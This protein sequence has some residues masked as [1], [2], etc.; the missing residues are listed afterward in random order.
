MKRHERLNADLFAG[1]QRAVIDIGSNTVRLVVYGGSLRSPT[2]IWNEK[3]TARLGKDP[4]RSGS[5]SEEAM[6]L[7]LQGLGRYAVLLRDLGIADVQVVATAA[8]RDAANGAEFLDR[9]RACGLEPRLLSGQE[10]AITGTMGVLCACPRA[11]GAVADL[12]GGSLELTRIDGK[13]CTDGR[14]LPL[15][16]LRLAAMRQ[17][18]STGFKRAVRRELRKAAW[19]HA[20]DRTLYLVGGTF[21]AMASYAIGTSATPIDDQHG[22]GMNADAALRL[23]RSVARK[24]PGQL[25]KVPKIPSM[26][27]AMLPDTAALFGILLE[28]LRPARVIFSA[29][30]LREGLLFERLSPSARAQ[31]P[32]LAGIA[33]FAAPRGGR[34][35]LAARVAGW[36]V[37]A[38]PAAGSGTERLRLAV[39][40]LALASMQT[41]PNMRLPQ[42]LDWALHKRWIDLDAE[43]RAML[44]AAL[45]ANC[46]ANAVP[47]ELELIAD[48]ATLREAMCWGLAIRLCRRLG[49]NSLHS[50]EASALHVDDTKLILLLGESVAA[51]RHRGLE[52]DLARLGDAL[53]LEPSIEIV[54]DTALPNRRLAKDGLYTSAA[55]DR[56]SMTAP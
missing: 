48:A 52:K 12:G 51:L 40:M 8:V 45:I 15:G 5:L 44:A 47:P 53:G 4:G 54:R 41:D 7:A 32:L 33:A 27:A 9:V 19:D 25:A 18:G 3:V 56:E 20:V 43:G 10:E 23:A 22:F 35:D 24:T 30:G 39:T 13:E 6:A 31:D 50:L 2:P 38:V 55:P 26:R 28:E 16:T 49:A 46:G 1:P 11:A 42:V 37:D 34:P 21:R 29:W 14:S 17:G 36:T